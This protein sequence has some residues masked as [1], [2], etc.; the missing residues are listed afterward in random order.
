VSSFVLDASGLLALLLD[1]EGAE[2]VERRLASSA[3]IS[4]ANLAEALSKIAEHGADPGAVARDLEAKGVLGGLLA[5]EP[6]T[7]EDA[8]TIAELRPA[9]KAYGLGLGGRICVALG[10][11]LDL[12]VLTADRAWVEL[13]GALGVKVYAFR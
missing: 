4:A 6:V 3:A 8:I 5:V 7:A 12:T 13:E 1:E 10:R 9:T 11:R 2:E